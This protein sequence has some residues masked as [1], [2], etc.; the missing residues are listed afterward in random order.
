MINTDIVLEINGELFLRGGKCER[1]GKHYF[2]KPLICLN[3]GNKVVKDVPLSK[4][5][6]LDVFVVSYIPLPGFTP[7]YA[8]GYVALEKEGIVVFAPFT[9]HENLRHGMEMEL[10]FRKI[11]WLGKERVVHMFSPVR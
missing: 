4:R 9:E 8:F 2:P 7:P 6:K 5:G 3:C 1:C 11:N 10:V